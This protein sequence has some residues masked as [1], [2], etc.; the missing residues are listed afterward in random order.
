MSVGGIRGAPASAAPPAPARA[1][2]AI[3]PFLRTCAAPGPLGGFPRGPGAGSPP[4][5]PPLAHGARTTGPRVPVCQAPLSGGVR[6]GPPPPVGPSVPEPGPGQAAP[7]RPAGGSAP[8]GSAERGVP[9]PWPQGRLLVS[10]GPPGT[11]GRLVC[12]TFPT[13][14]AALEGRLPGS[15][16]AHPQCRQSHLLWRRAAAG[17]HLQVQE[18]WLSL[19]SCGVGME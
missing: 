3:R 10:P 1:R 8:R 11:A 12:A 2:T 14:R 9:A 15:L 4:A 13:P 7:S 17:P 19:S 16:Q 6:V 5:R 18:P